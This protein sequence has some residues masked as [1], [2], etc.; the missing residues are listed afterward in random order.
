MYPQIFSVCIFCIILSNGLE[1]LAIVRN[2]N[3][4]EDIRS[5]LR[6]PENETSVKNVWRF[7]PKSGNLT[8]DLSRSIKVETCTDEND[9]QESLRVELV[10]K[11]FHTT[12]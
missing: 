11:N 3:S 6:F 12:S 4:I 1:T 10:R 5:C 8:V 2:S 9:K 7:D